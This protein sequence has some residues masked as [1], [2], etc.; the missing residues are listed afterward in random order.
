MANHC[1][2]MTWEVHELHRIYITIDY[3]VLH[4]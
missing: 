2:Y 1:G 3:K 4:L